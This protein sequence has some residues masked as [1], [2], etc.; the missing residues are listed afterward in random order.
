MRLSEEV[1]GANREA[2]REQL[3]WSCETNPQ[4]SAEAIVAETIKLAGL[5]EGHN[6]TKRATTL[7]YSMKESRKQKKAALKRIARNAKAMRERRL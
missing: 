5:G 4:K 3:Q 6:L 2:S 1:C 7:D